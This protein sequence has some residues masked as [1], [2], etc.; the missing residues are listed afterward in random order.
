MDEKKRKTLRRLELER[1]ATERRLLKARKKHRKSHDPS[2]HQQ[3]EQRKGGP[4]VHPGRKGGHPRQKW[5]KNEDGHDDD[6]DGE[7]GAGGEDQ[8]ELDENGLI[9]PSPVFRK[10]RRGAPTPTPSSPP[11]PPPPQFDQL[12]GEAKGEAEMARKSSALEDFGQGAPPSS[13][14]LAVFFSLSSLMIPLKI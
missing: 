13:F 11:P 6:G 9:A 10:R 7:E 14:F 1:Q 4:E 5:K 12:M 2:D 8:E 3:E